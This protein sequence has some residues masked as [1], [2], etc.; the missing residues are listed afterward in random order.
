LGVHV[1]SAA[2]PPVIVEL[3]VAA[4]PQDAAREL[5]PLHLRPQPLQLLPA[6]AGKKKKNTG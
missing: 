5:A 6:V 3:D 1:A 4:V 2:L